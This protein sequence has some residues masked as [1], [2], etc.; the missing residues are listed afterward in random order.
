M[1]VLFVTRKYPPRLGGME[2]LS[3]GLTTGYPEPKTII[4]LGRSQKH[5]VWFLPYVFA[6]VA[7]TAHR[8]DV[9][10]LGDAVL[11]PVGL[12]P[13]LL[14]K[15][16]VAVSVHGLDLTFP[17]PLYQAYL[18]LFL[19]AR[20]FIANSESTRRLAEGRGLAPVRTITIGVPERYFGIA[21]ATSQDPELEAKR[22]G[23]TVLLTV[24]RLVRRKGVAWFVR[25][26]LPELSNVLYL[27]IGV[28]PDRDDI[29]RAASET[30]TT[31]KLWLAG[32]INDSRL[33]HLLGG[34]D[35]FVMP[36][37]EVPGDTEGFGIVAIEA[38]ASGLP[39]VAARLEGIPDAIAD[40]QNGRLLESG[41][42]SAFIDALTPLIENAAE[43]TRQGE[44]GRAYTQQH[45]AW[46]RII[47]RYV[48]LFG[49]LTADEPVG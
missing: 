15:R 19:R 33:A 8:Y 7:L 49:E 3:F 46:P 6:R 42:A 26:V 10:H 41:N 14:F 17:H 29:L 11:S 39:V 25:N 35:I 27:V 22:A 13:R 31:D 2:S 21:R 30:G 12:L 36:N 28:G 18:K 48:E 32:K 43:R 9:I 45:N 1:R 38:A 47:E 20:V 23:R 37:V 4:A 34:S 5:L 16:Q 44:R 40:G 24:G